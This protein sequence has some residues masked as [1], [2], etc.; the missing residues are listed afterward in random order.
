MRTVQL[1]II[2]ALLAMICNA[3]T[4]VLFS[5][6][7]VGRN[8]I[9]DTDRSEAS[10]RATVEMRS[11]LDEDIRFWDHD[12]YNYSIGGVGGSL[13]DPDG[14]LFG[15]NSG[16]GSHR[17]SDANS[18]CVLTWSLLGHAFSDSTTS[19]GEAFADSVSRFDVVMIKPGY[20]DLHMN[21]KSSLEHYQG[22]VQDAVDWWEAN[23]SD[24]ILV[25]MTSSSLRHPS[26]YQGTA[27]WTDAAEAENDAAAYKQYADWLTGV[28]APAH[29]RIMAFDV[30]SRCVNLTGGATEL[31]FTRDEFKSSDHHLN[32][33]GS[34]FIQADLVDF[35]N[36]FSSFGNGFLDIQTATRTGTN[37]VLTWLSGDGGPYTAWLQADDVRGIVTTDT[38]VTIP[39]STAATDV[40][41]KDGTSVR[42]ANIPE[43]E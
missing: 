22:V 35:I 27:G 1:T 40:T 31:Y 30:F 24:Q 37:A 33:A 25:I 5:H 12:Y 28:L 43:V 19:A 9:G 13:L 38:T 39:M 23:T 16:F 29:S 14:D 2:I 15:P 21:T 42:K 3:Q 8:I 6:Q 10:H 4:S 20:R 26:D 18:G 41:V 34:D 7:S 17:C 32:T 11:L 36:S